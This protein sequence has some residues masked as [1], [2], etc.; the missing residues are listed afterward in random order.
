MQ[1]PFKRLMVPAVLVVTSSEI[2]QED[3]GK[4]WSY[5]GMCGG[6]GHTYLPGLLLLS[7]KSEIK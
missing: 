1:F 3:A 5:K 4:E 2:Q 6:V 7:L